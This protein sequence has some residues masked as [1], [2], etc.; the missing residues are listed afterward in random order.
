MLSRSIRNDAEVMIGV[1]PARYGQCVI[2]ASL[3]FR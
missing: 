1:A 2:M 3:A